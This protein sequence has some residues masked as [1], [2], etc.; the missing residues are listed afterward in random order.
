MF[1]GKYREAYAEQSPGGRPNKGDC[2]T[3]VHAGWVS[4]GVLC[5][6]VIGNVGDSGRTTGANLHFEVRQDNVARNPIFFLP[7]GEQVAAPRPATGRG[8]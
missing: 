7:A 8:G 1:S 3:P 4:F 2:G 5:G 6:E